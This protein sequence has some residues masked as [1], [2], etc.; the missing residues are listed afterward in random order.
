MLYL[1]NKDVKI[2]KFNLFINVIENTNF[3]FLKPCLKILISGFSFQLIFILP[4]WLSNGNVPD[5]EYAY[6]VTLQSILAQGFML[7]SSLSS[8]VYPDFIKTLRSSLNKNKVIF[9]KVFVINLM[10]VFF[11]YFS[12]G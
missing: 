5:V 1:D 7:L 6:I 11:S 8:V 4:G 2:L 3:D 12:G 10:Y 9:N